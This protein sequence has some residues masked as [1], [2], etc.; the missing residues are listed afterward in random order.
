MGLLAIGPAYEDVKESKLKEA[1]IPVGLDNGSGFAKDEP[2]DS[3]EASETPA[4]EVKEH[5]VEIT[6]EL[7]QELIALTDLDPETQLEEFTKGLEVE[8][9]HFETIEENKE[10]LAKIVADHIKEFPGVSYYDAL[11]TMEK[12]LKEQE[13]TEETPAS[14]ETAPV[15][16][17]PKVE[18]YK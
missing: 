6:P 8:M 10:V 14:E 1:G 17:E 9:E 2:V 11:A 12:E 4:E 3:H 5:D 18:D 13:G 16:E 7:A 15:V